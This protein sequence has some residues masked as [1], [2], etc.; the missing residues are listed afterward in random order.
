MIIVTE[1]AAALKTFIAKTSLH[2]LA[3]AFV[4]RMAL[5]FIMHRGRMSCSQAAGCIAS[6][7]LHRGQI[8][9]F[10]RRPR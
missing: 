10:L 5:T 7:T 3:Q 1:S 6:E 8:T 9:R 2:E 4:L